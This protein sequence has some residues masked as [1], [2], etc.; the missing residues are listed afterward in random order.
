MHLKENGSMGFA[1]WTNCDT[2]AKRLHTNGTVP[3]TPQ[4]IRLKVAA[5]QHSIES[6]ALRIRA[7]PL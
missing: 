1:T 7:S 6:V 4:L 2:A 5:T 3:H